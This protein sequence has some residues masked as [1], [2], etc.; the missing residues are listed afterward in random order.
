MEQTTFSFPS[1]KRDTCIFTFTRHVENTLYS[2]TRGTYTA[3]RYVDSKLTAQV[4]H[5]PGD[6]PRI[7]TLME[8]FNALVNDRA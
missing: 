4:H 7:A 3:W 5:L 1:I 2:R 6:G 8:T